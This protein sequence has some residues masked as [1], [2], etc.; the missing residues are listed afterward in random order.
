[1]LLPTLEWLVALLILE[2]LSEEC[3]LRIRRSVGWAAPGPAHEWRQ[4]QNHLGNLINGINHAI[5]KKHLRKPALR[6]SL[7]PWMYY[8]F[9]ILVSCD[10]IKIWDGSNFSFSNLSQCKLLGYSVLWVTLMVTSA[11]TQSTKV[12]LERPGVFVCGACLSPLQLSSGVLMTPLMAAWAA[13]FCF[14]RSSI[15]FLNSFSSESLNNEKKHIWWYM[16]EELQRSCFSIQVF[17][18]S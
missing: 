10:E 7:I 11:L 1:M 3:C 12:S 5:L 2:T 4:C 16:G 14:F 6:Q 8:V 18:S 17:G 9:Q 15:V 13:A